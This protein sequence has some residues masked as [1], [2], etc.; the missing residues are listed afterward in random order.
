MKA[1]LINS[2]LGY[3][4]TGRIVKDL[5]DCLL[6]QGH[7]PLVAFGRGKGLEG[8]QQLK[9]GNLVDQAMHLASSRLF[10]DHG[11]KSKLVTKRFI[12][13]IEAFNPDLI[14]LHNIH[15]YF[16]NYPVLME[17]IRDK[18]L[19]V[20]WTLHDCWSFT[21]H[22]AY[23][24]FVGCD[25]WKEL[26]FDCPQKNAYPES[27]GWDKSS[28]NYK[29]KKEYFNAIGA[30]MVSPSQW[31]TDLVKQSFLNQRAITIPNGID[32]EVFR[33][34]PEAKLNFPKDKKIILGVASV[35][36][37]R[38]GLSFFEELQHQLPD[39]YHLALVGVSDKEKALF[40]NSKVTLISRTSNV[41]ELVDIYSSAD[42]L[43]N[44]TL[45]DNFPTVNL[46]AQACGLP[47]ITFDTGGSPETITKAT[48][49]VVEKSIDAIL[50]GLFELSLLS[51]EDLRKH[52]IK[53]AK[54]YDKAY[55]YQQYI[56][57]YE[58]IIK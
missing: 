40:T 55:R 5:H 35:W 58:E 30:I 50:Q 16:L 3:G 20:V 24:D 21:G 48:G 34:N 32:L 15:G 37:P 11:L 2:V 57:L 49:L 25:K 26:C 43:L 46:E 39:Q 42:V 10:D 22:C 41:Q 27:I 45:E 18:K 6:D 52:C 7:Q 33:Y 14:H 12:K 53:H 28:R 29:L 9:I 17:Y 54:N 51:R 4:S 23:F 8:Y 36:E 19:P 1:L 44:P 47:V 38:K 56:E 13:E 31:L